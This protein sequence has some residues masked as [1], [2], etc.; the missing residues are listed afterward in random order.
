M[1]ILA[2]NIAAGLCLHMAA[3]EINE[4]IV[5]ESNK[6]IIEDDYK[7]LDVLHHFTSGLKALGGEMAYKGIDELR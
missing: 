4:N 1:D 2:P 3:R 6:R 5:A 7:L